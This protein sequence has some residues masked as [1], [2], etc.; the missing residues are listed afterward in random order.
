VL[1][2]RAIAAIRAEHVSLPIVFESVAGAG[3]LGFKGLRPL[4]DP[5]VVYSFHYYTPHEIT[6]Q[7]V[8]D[9][10]NQSI[11]YPAG[12]QWGLGRWDP[13]LGV[14]TIDKSRLALEMREVVAF[15]RRYHL[16]IY[17]GEFSCVRWAPDGSATRFVADALD[18]F[19]AQKWSWT[20]HEFRGWPGWDAEIASQDRANTT[21][22]VDAP[23]MALL[24]A[25]LAGT[26]R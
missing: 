21:R 23:T 2:E 5:Q 7:H 6:H 3:A 16:P 18:I 26:R 10:W 25:H 20:Y 9:P 1:A 15:Q 4:A 12:P 14:S 8:A 11:P 22:S 19:T 13:E 17:V 24:R